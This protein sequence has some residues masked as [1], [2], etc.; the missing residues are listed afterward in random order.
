MEKIKMWLFKKRYLEKIRVNVL[1]KQI[2]Y[3]SI[4]FVIGAFISA[5]SFNLFYVPMNFVSG[6]L[7]GVA[8]ILNKFFSTDINLVILIGNA[9]FI[10]LSICTLGF[11]KS[12]LSIVG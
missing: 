8:I 5:L 7:G 3:K 9:T 1:R 2:M 10:I 6:G 4:L 12:L 11:R